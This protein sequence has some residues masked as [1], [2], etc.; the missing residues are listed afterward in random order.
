LNSRLFIISTPSSGLQAP[1]R[2]ASMK[3]VRR[4]MQVRVKEVLLSPIRRSALKLTRAI[5]CTGSSM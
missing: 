3:S 2:A 4:L 1:E 5:L